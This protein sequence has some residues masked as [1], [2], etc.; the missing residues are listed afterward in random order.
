MLRSVPLA[1][2][3]LMFVQPA[4]AATIQ[5]SLAAFQ[6]A[7]GADAITQTVTLGTLFDPITTVALGATTITLS[8]ASDTVDQS[9]FGV[10]PF[11]NGYTGQVVDSTDGTETLTFSTPRS[12]FGVTVSPDVPLFGP[13]NV[14]FT[15]RL[16]DGTS[17]S[18][19]NS[20]ATGGT[21]FIGFTGGSETSVTITTSSPD[22]AFGQ[23]LTVPEPTSIL[24]LGTVLIPLLRRGRTLL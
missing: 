5:T 6:A 8:G 21:Q 24:L 16:G 18:L 3:A 4:A 20:F 17:T 10:S 12:N 1:A 7:V 14:T 13:T 19:T 23:F 15:V 9:G 2:T 22:F 11:T